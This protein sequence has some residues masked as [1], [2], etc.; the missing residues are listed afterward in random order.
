MSIGQNWTPK[1]ISQ[2]GYHNEYSVRGLKVYS[3]ITT[4]KPI[5]IFGRIVEA[6][7]RIMEAGRE[8]FTRGVVLHARR[9]DLTNGQATQVPVAILM[10]GPVTISEDELYYFDEDGNALDKQ[11]IHARLKMYDIFVGGPP[12]L[13]NLGAFTSGYSDGYENQA[14]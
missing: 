4:T 11:V 14:P 3:G 1:T 5:D 13:V 6:D 12:P 2:R 10:Q 8:G 9:A 7:G